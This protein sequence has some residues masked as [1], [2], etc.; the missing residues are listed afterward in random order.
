MIIMGVDPGS[1]VTGYGL[2]QEEN[3]GWRAIQYGCIRT[4]GARAFP[5]KLEMIYS[6]L[7]KVISEHHPDVVVVERGF[8]GKNLRTALVMGQV[9]GVS[10]LVASRASLPVLEYSPREVKLAVTGFGS[11][12]KEQVQYMIEQLLKIEEASVAV[13]ASDALA[14]ALCHANRLSIPKE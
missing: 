12:S 3:A 9:L 4:R 1:V 11:A 7:M 2:I 14:V 8:S 6:G 10:L 13:D 5:E